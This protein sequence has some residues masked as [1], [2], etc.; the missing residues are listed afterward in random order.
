MAKREKR[1]VVRLHMRVA[2]NGFLA[3]AT[4]YDE[5]R[6]AKFKRGEVVEIIE[7]TLPKTER[8]ASLQR[9]YW[10]IVGKIG[11]AGGEDA[12]VLSNKIKMACGRVDG[13]VVLQGKGFEQTAFIPRSLSDMDGPEFESF[14]ADACVHIAT[15][16]VPGVE[17]DEILDMGQDALRERMR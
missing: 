13:V 16:V 17:V 14:F 6:L 4:A 9:K 12:T 8:H 11:T 3:P 7:P 2:A 10:A 15:V 5:E 1:D